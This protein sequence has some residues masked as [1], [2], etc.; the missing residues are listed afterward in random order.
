[1][2]KRRRVEPAKSDGSVEAGVRASMGHP[3]YG[4]PKPKYATTRR[5]KC[6]NCKKTWKFSDKLNYSVC[7]SC[8]KGRLS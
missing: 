5:L 7:P 4:Y 2:S 3:K 8:K 1:V 6:G